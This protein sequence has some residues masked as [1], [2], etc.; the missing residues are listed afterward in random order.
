[1]ARNMILSPKMV[2]L[3]K[4]V[5][6]WDTTR[7]FPID[8]TQQGKL[9]FDYLKG[10]EQS[11]F[12]AEL[13]WIKTRKAY[14]LGDVIKVFR[15]ADKS[16]QKGDT[17]LLLRPQSAYIRIGRC[18]SYWTGGYSV[19]RSHTRKCKTSSCHITHN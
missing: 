7:N 10:V 6:K 17:T 11:I 3:T 4:K 8:S 18:T 2:S 19:S 9:M 13:S 5:S 1:M 12:Q 15:G 16:I 14:D